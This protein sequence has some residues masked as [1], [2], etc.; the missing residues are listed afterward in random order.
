MNMCVSPN[1]IYNISDSS[2]YVLRLS[3]VTVEAVVPTC[4]SVS[5][6]TWVSDSH[7]LDV[8]CHSSLNIQSYILPAL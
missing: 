4:P 1:D 3:S 6:M 7:I 2:S 8:E 5:A